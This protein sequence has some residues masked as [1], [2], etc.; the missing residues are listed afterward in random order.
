MVCIGGQPIASGG[1]N[2][3]GGYRINPDNS[4]TEI[5]FNVNDVVI[6]EDT[7]NGSGFGSNHQ[8]DYSSGFPDDSDTVYEV[9]GGGGDFPETCAWFKDGC[10]DEWVNEDSPQGFAITPDKLYL[11][12]ISMP[13]GGTCLH[14]CSHACTGAHIGPPCNPLVP[15]QDC[16]DTVADDSEPFPTT[17]PHTNWYKCYKRFDVKY[18]W[19]C[20]PE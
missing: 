5:T 4:R 16:Y 11:G 13:K 2:A 1:C 9:S 10:P 20:P 19:C 12:G 7:S 6:F 15:C 8:Y 17:C 14:S 3:T 18:Y